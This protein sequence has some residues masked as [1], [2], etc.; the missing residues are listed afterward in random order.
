MDSNHAE[1][2]AQI[3]NAISERRTDAL[4]AVLAFLS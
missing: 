3:L 1:A 4:L 2:S